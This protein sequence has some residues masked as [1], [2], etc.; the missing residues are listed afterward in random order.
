M[1]RKPIKKS[2]EIISNINEKEIKSYCEVFESD[3][4]I[5]HSLKINNS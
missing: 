3:V 5:L 2:Q 1:S 4:Q